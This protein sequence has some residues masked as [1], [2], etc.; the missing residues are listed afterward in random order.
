MRLITI[1]IGVPIMF[2]KTFWFSCVLAALALLA[3]LGACVVQAGP[4]AGGRSYKYRVG[5]DYSPS[6]PATSLAGDFAPASRGEPVFYAYYSP[7]VRSLGGGEEESELGGQNAD[8]RIELKVPANAEVW[9]DGHKTKQ[10]GAARSFITPPIQP[11]K[12]FTYDLRVRWTTD[13]GIV[14]DVTRPIQVR[15]GRQTMV[16]F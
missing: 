4:P 5:R 2:R 11:G 7:P 16:G 8:A 9:L 1:S 3:H 13:A 14:V 10:D 15:A 6:A 12:S